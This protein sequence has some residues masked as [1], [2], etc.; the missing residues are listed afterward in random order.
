[1]ATHKM[2]YEYSVL[3]TGR[4]CS[5]SCCFLLQFD[6]TTIC[7]GQ[8]YRSSMFYGLIGGKARMRCAHNQSILNETK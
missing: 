1:M 2:Y 6:G 4:F 3:R 5:L 8:L 7:F